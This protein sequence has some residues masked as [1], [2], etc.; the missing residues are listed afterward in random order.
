M[1]EELILYK[2]A[3]QVRELAQAIV[4]DL[5]SVNLRKDRMSKQFLQTLENHIDHLIMQAQ[6]LKQQLRQLAAE[7]E[8]RD[9]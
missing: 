9:H 8:Q 7:L 3:K 1:K 2:R 4:R 6:G 5:L